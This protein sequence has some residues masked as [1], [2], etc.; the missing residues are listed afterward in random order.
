MRWAESRPRCRPPLPGT[1]PHPPQRS[2]QPRPQAM[3]LRVLAFS[4]IFFMLNSF[5]L[6]KFAESETPA[7]L[8]VKE[9]R[10]LKWM[11]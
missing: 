6:K 3:S 11:G 8:A 4:H 9:I 1:L 5:H 10:G 7:P 2:R